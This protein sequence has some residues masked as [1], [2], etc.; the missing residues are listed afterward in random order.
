MIFAFTLL[1]LLAFEEPRWWDYPGFE[2]W[3]FINLAVFILLLVYI[4]TRKANLGEAFRTRRE[5]I[6]RE[7][8]RAQQERDA[9]VAKLKEVEERL[10]RLDTEV[11][12]IK[13]QSARET[14]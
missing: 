14:A 1:N 2:L 4:L 8:A 13:E 3:K 9:A 7:L 11:A 12:T 6:K 5:T 10:S